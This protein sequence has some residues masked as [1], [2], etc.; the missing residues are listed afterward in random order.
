MWTRGTVTS[1]RGSPASFA[2]AN[3]DGPHGLLRLW[4]QV[5][6]SL[7]C[8]AQYLPWRPSFQSSTSQPNIRPSRSSLG[9]LAWDT[10]ACCQGQ[11]TLG[12]LRL[13]GTGETC[14]WCP[15]TQDRGS[16]FPE[17]QGRPVV[18]SPC[19]HIGWDTQD[20]TREVSTPA[21]GT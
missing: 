6:P 16:T 20:R 3:G 13:P 21:G 7:M 9:G 18:L 14:Q 8:P 12:K 17:T 1:Q 19:W 5:P 11:E 2:L 10:R 15:G 4:P